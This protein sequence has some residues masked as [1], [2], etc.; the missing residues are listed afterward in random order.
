MS[1]EGSQK[2][3]PDEKFWIA[4]GLYVILGA[5]I[6]FT[7]GDGTTIVFGK[8]VQLRWIPMFVVGTFVFRTVMA[9]EAEKIRRSSGGQ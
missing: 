8:Q 4:L 6:W 5:V 1:K 7:L 2:R 3:S 9:R